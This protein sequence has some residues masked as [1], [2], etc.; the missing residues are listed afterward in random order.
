[1]PQIDSQG[2]V[3]IPKK[4]RDALRLNPGTRIDF[5]EFE[6]GQFTMIPLTGSVQELKGMFK[7]KRK[8]PITIEEI[9]AAIARGAAKWR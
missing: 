8:K 2:R 1:V 5:V 9:D 3:T 7:G 4:I 6:K